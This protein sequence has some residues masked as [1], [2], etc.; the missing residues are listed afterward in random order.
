MRKIN[1]YTWFGQRELRHCPIHFIETKTAI[2][3]ESKQWILENLTGRFYLAQKYYDFDALEYPCFE[4]P[5]EAVLY[6]LT[7]S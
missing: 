7:W 3:P 2:T 5:Q 4:D 1:L 6:E